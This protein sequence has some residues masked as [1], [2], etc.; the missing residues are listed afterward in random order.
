MRK[1]YKIII[2]CYDQNNNVLKE[3]NIKPKKKYKFELVEKILIKLPK[4]FKNKSYMVL[5]GKFVSLDPY[6]G[7]SHHL[8]SDVKH[9]KIEI[10]KGYVPKF[11]DLRKKFVNK[12]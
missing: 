11:K 2:A 9:S 3:L 1:Y 4:Y 8:L 5:D 7:T 12:V 10:S 6:L